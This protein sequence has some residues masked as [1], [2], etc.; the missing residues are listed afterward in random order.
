M[1]RLSNLSSLFISSI[2]FLLLTSLYAV[3]IKTV[4]LI[5]ICLSVLPATWFLISLFGLIKGFILRT[6]ETKNAL[7][8]VI[9]LF[10]IATFT[11]FGVRN[12]FWVHTSGYV[13][14]TSSNVVVK[15]DQAYFIIDNIYYEVSDEVYEQLRVNYNFK[16]EAAWNKFDR[17]Y[18]KHLKLNTK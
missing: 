10:L 9:G 14:V 16:Y 1:K 3:N 13:S 2:L 8:V 7:V 4:S 17:G 15:D 6:N 11:Y 12:F 5:A 18:S